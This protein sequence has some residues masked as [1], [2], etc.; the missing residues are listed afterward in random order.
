MTPDN[1]ILALDVD[2]AEEALSWVKRLKGR[3][4]CFKVGLQLYTRVGS[5]LVKHIKKLGGD[6]FL[7]LKFCDI[8]NTVAKAVE[9][10]CALDVRFLTIHTLGGPHM[11]RAAVD[12]CAKDTTVLGVTVLTSLDDS[13]LKVMGFNYTASAEV[14]Q[15]ARVAKAAGLNALVCSPL[16]TEL[17]RHEFGD[18]FTLVTPGV[19]PPGS[20]QD[21]QSRVTTP[22]KAIA[23]GSNYVVMGRPILKAENPESLL[24][25][26][27]Q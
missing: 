11:I 10:V 8:P 14:L 5:D 25:S 26:L 3:I 22:Q 21:D 20:S 12:A 19:R 7:D 17:I 15:L 4:G 9:S 23:E 2:T 18:D 24:D 6:V 1:L 16:E 13:D 27:F